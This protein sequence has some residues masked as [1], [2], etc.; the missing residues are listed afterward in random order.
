MKMDGYSSL[1]NLFI[2]IE[3][4]RYVLPFFLSFFAYN[5]FY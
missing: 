4:L 1:S 3:Y 5:A 2:L